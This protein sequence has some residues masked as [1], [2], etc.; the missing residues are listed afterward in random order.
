M[1]KIE[2]HPFLF[3]LVLTLLFLG[4]TKIIFGFYWGWID[5]VYFMNVLEGIDYKEP[6]NSLFVKYHVLLSG[7]YVACYKAFP[8]VNWYGL[9][10]YLYLYFA[11]SFIVFVLLK[12]LL[13]ARVSLLAIVIFLVLFFAVFLLEAVYMLTFT[14]LS[15]MLFGSAVLY[16]LLQSNK[17]ILFAIPF[18]I[19]GLLI[20]VDVVFF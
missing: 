4:F 10:N 20:R 9:F 16:M 3:S 17:N 12:I 19:I 2:R 15:M 7:F 11:I 18:A 5:D 13:N 8:A 6:S 1:S 14:T